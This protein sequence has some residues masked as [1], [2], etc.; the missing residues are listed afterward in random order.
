MFREIKVSFLPPPPSSLSTSVS[1]LHL[2]GLSYSDEGEYELTMSVCT[3]RKYD[4]FII[5]QWHTHNM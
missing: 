4:L 3:Q 5:V 1:T 2:K